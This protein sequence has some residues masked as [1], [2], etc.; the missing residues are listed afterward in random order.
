[1]RQAC[2][3]KEWL[4]WKVLGRE[5]VDTI[6]DPS[7]TS[8][9]QNKVHYMPALVTG[10][11]RFCRKG[12]G[13]ETLRYAFGSL[14]V[15]LLSELSSIQMKLGELFG[16]N[17]ALRLPSE[18]KDPRKQLVVSGRRSLLLVFGKPSLCVRKPSL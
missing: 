9:Q 4:R 15:Q 13:G 11:Y 10:D 14:V 12:G 5:N 3:F 17:T 7:T 6:G 16:R 18:M 2:L 8:S 1:M